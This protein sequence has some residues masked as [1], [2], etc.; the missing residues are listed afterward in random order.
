[1]VR[2]LIFIALL[3]FVASSTINAEEDGP[4]TTES[5]RGVNLLGSILSGKSIQKEANTT[6]NSSDDDQEDELVEDDEEAD[7]TP[8]KSMTKRSYEIN[9]SAKR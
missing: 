2:S 1:M 3:V 4:S 9:K 6:S 8:S 7:S 5:S